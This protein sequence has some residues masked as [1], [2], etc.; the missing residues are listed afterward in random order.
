VPHVRTNTELTFFDSPSANKIYAAKVVFT[1]QTFLVIDGK[2]AYQIDWTA[3]LV[4]K[5]GVILTTFDLQK[6][7]K[8]TKIPDVLMGKMLPLGYGDA[9]TDKGGNVTFGQKIEVPNP[10]T[11]VQ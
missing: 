5:A 3:T 8:P 10:I 1:Y 11:G 6:G 2:L 7:F 9:N 4:T